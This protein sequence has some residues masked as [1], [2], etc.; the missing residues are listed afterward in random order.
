MPGVNRWIAEFGDSRPGMERQFALW[1]GRL[2]PCLPA[3]AASAQADAAGAGD[4]LE[5]QA[6]PAN[7]PHPRHKVAG[8]VY[9]KANCRRGRS[10]LL[11]GYGNPGRLD[12][13]L[14][15]ALAAAIE[16]RAIPGVR[17][18]SD[19]QLTV[20][21]AHAVSRHD[22]V[23]FADASVDGPEPF[24]FGRW[25][26]VSAAA[27]SSHAVTPAEVMGLAQSLFGRAAEAYVLG[28]RGY[29]FDE[30][31]ERLSAAAARNLDAAIAFADR[32]VRTLTAGGRMDESARRD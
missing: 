21:D 11:I 19:Y 10:V 4:W 18:E 14:G 23:I 22:V 15:P 32:A 17:V 25:T 29:A 27:F 28:I 6:F 9:H 7:L 20:E 12:D 13:G 8:G 2:P 3:E 26:E 1:R 30:F 16:A 24:S 31:G 5:K